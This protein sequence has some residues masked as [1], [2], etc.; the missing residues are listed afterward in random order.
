MTTEIHIHSREDLRRE[1]QRL[2]IEIKECEARLRSRIHSL[3]E[4]LT[5]STMAMNVIKKVSSSPD[6]GVIG[7]GIRNAVGHLAYN[8]LFAGYSWPV[9]MLLT[10]VSKNVASHVVHDKGPEYVQKIVSWWQDRKKVA[11]PKE[12]VEFSKRSMELE[13]REFA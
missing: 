3:E 10:Y 5:P 6:G 4:S 11:P 7:N 13:K 2:Q 12:V 1:K 9:R 8:T